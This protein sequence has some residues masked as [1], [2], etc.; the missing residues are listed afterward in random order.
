MLSLVTLKT[1]KWAPR[2]ALLVIATGLIMA[3][4]PGW[5]A[6]EWPAQ[7]AVAGFTVNGI[8]PES[9]NSA[10]GM[11]Q[12]PG[13]GG[14]EISLTRSSRDDIAGSGSI[15][16][17]V[18]GID[19]QGSFKLDNNGL[20]CRGGVVKT[21][22]K[23]ITDADFTIGNRGELSGRGSIELG[24]NRISTDFSASGSSIRVTGSTSARASAD[25]QLAKYS[26]EG[27]LELQGGSG[28]SVA[29]NAQ[30]R[31]ERRGKLAEQ[32]TTYNVSSVQVNPSNGNGTANIDGVNV[33]FDFF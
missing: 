33:T 19:V 31:V 7:V 26:F 24:S 9:A 11:L 6:D 20:K 27:N 18:S 23:P 14:K 30:G 1:N 5:C 28:G 3:A 12:I 10:K 16:A 32:V 13:A 17:R 2:V 15:S 4:V 29:V 8:R 22:P 25:T 21:N